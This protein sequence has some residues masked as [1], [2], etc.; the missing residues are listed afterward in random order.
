MCCND[1]E[2][3]RLFVAGQWGS[4]PSWRGCGSLKNPT[5]RG[6]KRSNRSPDALWSMSQA[7]CLKSFLWVAV[8]VNKLGVAKVY[9]TWMDMLKRLVPH[10]RTHRL[11]VVIA[12]MLQYAQVIAHEKAESN[13]K[14]KQLSAIFEESDEDD[15]D[16]DNQ[17]LLTLAESLLTD[18]G[19]KYQRTSSRG[20]NYSIAEEAV[21]EFLHWED[22]PWES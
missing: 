5:A 19:V 12:G 2:E 20:Q 4:Q 7:R 16:E 1:V 21:H 8:E 22:M 3:F 18:A 15:M 17:G 9:G 10:G 13:N 11:S 6:G 14:A